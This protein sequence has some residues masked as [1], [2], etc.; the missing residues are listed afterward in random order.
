MGNAVC[1]NTRRSKENNVT[2][3]SS[4]LESGCDHSPNRFHTTR[5]YVLTYQVGGWTLSHG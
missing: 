1:T 2:I 4:F 5:D 3:V